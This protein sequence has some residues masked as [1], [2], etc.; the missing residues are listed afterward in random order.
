M[1]AWECE[2]YNAEVV[3]VLARSGEA[4]G[5][6]GMMQ[7]LLPMARRLGLDTEGLPNDDEMGAVS[8]LIS[9]MDASLL[10]V[11]EDD[12]T[13]WRVAGQ[14]DEAAPHGDVED[15]ARIVGKASK[16]VP[17]GG[18]KPF[19]T[20]PGMNLLPREQRRKMEREQPASG[21]E[22]E[23]LAGPALMADIWRSTADRARVQPALRPWGPDELVSVDERHVQVYCA[24]AIAVQAP[25]RCG[26]D[27]RLWKSWAR[28]CAA[29]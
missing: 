28:S 27:W 11:G 25:P 5:A 10:V 7:N 14:L 13:D 6:I 21:R 29:S 8:G 20:F 22:N 3:H 26:R 9:P 2:L 4:L 19:L 23:Y 24:A 12:E 1:L 15:R 16:T 18:C 17:V